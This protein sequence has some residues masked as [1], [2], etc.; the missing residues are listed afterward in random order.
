M[1]SSCR[2]SVRGG[3]YRKSD[4]RCLYEVRSVEGVRALEAECSPSW[5]SSISNTEMRL[6][7]ASVVVDR[8]GGESRGLMEL[9]EGGEG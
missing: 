5:V 1:V 4:I 9:M 6:R 2:L 8:T 3:R 7:R